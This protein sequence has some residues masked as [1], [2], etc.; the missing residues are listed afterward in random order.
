MPR[1]S[2]VRRSLRSFTGGR[3][4]GPAPAAPEPAERGRSGYTLWQRAW[5][6]FTG[7]V[8]P[9]RPAAV[10]PQPAAVHPRPGSVHPRPAAVHPWL[11]AAHPRPGSVRTGTG[12]GPDGAPAG[13]AGERPSSQP[14]APGW[15]ALPGLPAAG[16]LSAAAGG[17]VVLEASTPDGRARFLVRRDHGGAPGYTLELVVRDPGDTD[18]PVFST[19]TYGR[20][21]EEERVL[22]VP[23]VPARFGPAAAYVR[24]RGFDAGTTWAATG[25]SPVPPDADWD[26][27]SVADSVGA[28]LNEATRDAW[29]TIGDLARGE[30]RD[31][32]VRALR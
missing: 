12:R 13:R 7:A 1:G 25:P 31:A 10:H 23:V 30:L 29:R 11:T 3:P 9:P 20:P 6:S 16:A 21:G 19:V 14:S 17:A 18:R 28:A 4:P 32:I 15:F 8:L 24:L 26:P 5:A 2:L 22:L 27:A